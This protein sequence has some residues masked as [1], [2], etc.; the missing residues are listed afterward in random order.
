M[1][2]VLGTLVLRWY[3]F[4]F[5]A[6]FLVASARDLGWRGT[7][8]FAAWVWTLAW[9][10]ELVST[11]VGVPFGLY[12]YTGATRGQELYIADVPLMDALSFTFLRS[13]E[14][15]VGKE[16]RSRWSPYDIKKK[17]KHQTST[18]N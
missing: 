16:C 5:V 11:R 10:C 17:E 2:L 8:V 18:T 6:C 3:V 15:R 13:E 14:R 9:A 7:L 4:T 1:D 12:Y